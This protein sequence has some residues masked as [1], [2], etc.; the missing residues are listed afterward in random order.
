MNHERLDTVVGDIQ[1]EVETPRRVRI[2]VKSGKN[3]IHADLFFRV[4]APTKSLG[5]PK[6]ALR[7]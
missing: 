5:L 7:P 4:G 3:D 2:L 1:V 6:L